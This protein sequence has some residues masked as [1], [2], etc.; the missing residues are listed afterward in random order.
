MDSVPPA[1]ATVAAPD[2]TRSA[3]MAI[4][5]RPDAQN[6]FTVTADAEIGRPA[7]SEAMRATFRPCSPS[8]IAH[9]STTSS[10][11]AA[12]TA[13]TRAS[14]SRRTIAARSSGRV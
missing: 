7:R 13:G 8:G 3:A 5:S 1:S 4:A 10:T 11:S 12:S 9:P 2:R 6:R 14:A